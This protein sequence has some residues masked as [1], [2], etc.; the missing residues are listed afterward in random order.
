MIF[1]I[2]SLGLLVCNSVCVCVCV[3]VCMCVWRRSMSVFS[4]NIMLALYNGF[5]RV[6]LSSVLWKSL[7]R[8]TI[9]F[10]EMFGRIHQRTP[11]VLDFSLRGGFFK[12]SDYSRR[13]K[14]KEGERKEKIQKLRVLWHII[15][16]IYKTLNGKFSTLHFHFLQL[17]KY[18]SHKLWGV[19]FF[20]F[21]KS[22]TSYVPISVNR[23]YFY[24]AFFSFFL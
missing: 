6:L 17:L 5:E 22:Y 20:F 3:C 4:I 15:Q 8:I 16:G 14:S 12:G 21:L 18:I 24:L 19:F 11:L 9:N 13:I 7:R 1:T 2:M 10:L 23:R